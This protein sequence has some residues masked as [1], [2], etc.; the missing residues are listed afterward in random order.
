M[1]RFSE[2]V[3]LVTG[4]G[5]G[6]GAAAAVRFLADGAAVCIADLRAEALAAQVEAL[7]AGPRLHAV[8]CD[9]T[10]EAAVNSLIAEVATH[11]GRLDVLVNNAGFGSFA[12]VEELTTENWRRVQA[13]CLDSVFFGS[14][15]AMPHLKARQGCI[16]NTA[17]IS[18]LRGDYGFAAY[19]A[20]KGGVV[21]LTRNMA[22]DHAR[23][24][25][26][27][28]AVCPG[29]TATPLT[30]K[31]TDRPD[32]MAEYDRRIPMRRPG[33]PEEMAAAIAFLASEDA[34]YITG[35]TLAV[36]GGITAATGQPN[37]LDLL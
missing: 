31:F 29:L 1:A 4:G 2:K 22:I 19:N 5:S 34:S 33:R 28:N 37:F 27:V 25:V 11:F 3:V 9:V 7:N 35:V 13:V 18:G 15:A 8:E 12:R 26:R 32:I 14:R 10:D 36:D 21:N 6:I 17:S 23:D 30:T 20:A 24:G 16:V